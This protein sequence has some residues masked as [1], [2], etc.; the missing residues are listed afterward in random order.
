MSQNAPVEKSVVCLLRQG[1][2]LAFRHPLAGVQLPKGTREPG[3]T[4]E[5]TARREMF[6]EV[7][8]HLSGALVS[9]G[10]WE[11]PE[12]AAIWHVF[13]ADGS[14]A[15]PL[16]WRHMPTGGGAER[17][18]TFDVIWVDIS[19]AVDVFHPLFLPVIDLVQLYRD[20]SAKARESQS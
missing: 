7:G 1:A 18:L 17:G 19:S 2:V 8:L 11:C 12:P 16:S 13:V 9:L 5:E 15:L 3:E 20:Q 10:T 4:P 14:D 6:E